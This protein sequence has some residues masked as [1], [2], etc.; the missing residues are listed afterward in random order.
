M[1][2]HLSSRAQNLNCFRVTCNRAVAMLQNVRLHPREGRRV[3]PQ[4]ILPGEEKRLRVDP[5]RGAERVKGRE[6]VWLFVNVNEIRANVLENPGH[7]GIVVEMKLPI[8]T[9]RLD[10]QGVAA[11]VGAFE[12]NN[13]ALVAPKRGYDNGQFEVGVFREFFKFLLVLSDDARFADHY[14]AHGCNHKM[15][16]GK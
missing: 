15:A 10:E 16:N 4:E 1:G 12:R 8:E 14:D 2:A 7:R 5:L 11:R 13:A 3:A 6:I 9:H